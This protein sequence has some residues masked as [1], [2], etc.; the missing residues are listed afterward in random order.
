MNGFYLTNYHK[1]MGTQPIRNYFQQVGSTSGTAE[2]TN[3]REETEIIEHPTIHNDSNPIQVDVQS[4][5]YIVC[6]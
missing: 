5:I 1:N 4:F 2:N 3:T 6:L